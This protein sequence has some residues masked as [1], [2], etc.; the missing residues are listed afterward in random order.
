MVNNFLGL[1]KFNFFTCG[2]DNENTLVIAFYVGRRH[3]DTL[4]RFVTQCL[5]A[6]KRTAIFWQNIDS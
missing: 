2:F 5:T 3:K 1:D 6:V 4:S